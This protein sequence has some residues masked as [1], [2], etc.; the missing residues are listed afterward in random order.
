[1]PG[2]EE[3]TS[4]RE[5]IGEHTSQ[6]HIH[7]P[8]PVNLAA[9]RRIQ[10]FLELYDA[11]MSNDSIAAG[12][13]TPQVGTAGLNQSSGI[14]APAN[15]ETPSDSAESPPINHPDT[16]SEDN[17]SVVLQENETRTPER[18]TF[19]PELER[20]LNNPTLPCP[21]PICTVCFDVMPV[22][23]LDQD[24]RENLSPDYERC[25]VLLCGH[26]IGS[27]CFDEYVL[28][29]SSNR[30]N[31]YLQDEEQESWFI[32]TTCPTCRT[33]LGCRRCGESYKSAR[34][35]AFTEDE[36]VIVSLIL[37]GPGGPPEFCEDCSEYL[38]E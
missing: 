23:G 5:I 33:R 19:W 14:R 11:L 10:A 34:L 30:N 36:W 29:L 18:V 32:P 24:V 38:E 13:V 28:E 7:A 16:A 22:L 31:R 8:Q 21:E 3:I 17:T 9:V 25:V 6:T 1:M 4:P 20:Y 35:P 26:L 2:Q 12:D 27:R 37:T 15:S